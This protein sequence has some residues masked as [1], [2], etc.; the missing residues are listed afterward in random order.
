MN[1]KQT[2]KWLGNTLAQSCDIPYCHYQ[3]LCKERLKLS[4]LQLLYLKERGYSWKQAWEFKQV[5][6]MSPKEGV[7]APFN[8]TPKYNTDRSF[9][10]PHRHYESDGGPTLWVG[11]SL[12]IRVRGG[13][14]S[15]IPAGPQRGVAPPSA[16]HHDDHR[17]TSWWRLYLTVTWMFFEFLRK[18]H[19]MKKIKLHILVHQISIV[20]TRR[21]FFHFA[22]TIENLVLKNYYSA[23]FFKSRKVVFR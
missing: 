9:D 16:G 13:G 20:C 10:Y 12:T 3:S 18:L 19:E 7:Y 6:C 22:Q 8:R 2:L 21:T 17:R 15:I 23:I 1:W 5:C 14:A 11:V 4:P